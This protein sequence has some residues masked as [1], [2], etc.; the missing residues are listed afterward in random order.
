[1]LRRYQARRGCASA[2]S[3]EFAAPY[4]FWLMQTAALGWLGALPPPWSL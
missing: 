2:S 3:T 1:M 4:C